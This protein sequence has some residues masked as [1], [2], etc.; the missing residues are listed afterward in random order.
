MVP[1][2]LVGL[3][4]RPGAAGYHDAFEVATDGLASGNMLAEAVLHGLCEL[5]E[6]DAYAQLELMPAQQARR[7]GGAAFRRWDRSLP[8]C[9]NSSRGADSNCVFSK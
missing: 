2:A 3:D 7:H 6:R 1:W 4:H 8:D 9:S 5:V